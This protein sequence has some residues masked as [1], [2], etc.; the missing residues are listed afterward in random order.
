MMAHS[1]FLHR[2]WAADKYRRGMLG[3]DGDFNQPSFNFMILQQKQY[4]GAPIA[5]ATSAA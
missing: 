3:Q 5:T 1:V 4:L 2:L